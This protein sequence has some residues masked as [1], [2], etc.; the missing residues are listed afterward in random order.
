MPSPV[1]PILPDFRGS[2]SVRTGF[3]PLDLGSDPNQAP[4]WETNERE[5][6]EIARQVVQA[7]LKKRVRVFFV[8]DLYAFAHGFALSETA[9]PCFCAPRA[10]PTVRARGGAL[11]A[12]SR[13]LIALFA[14]S[15]ESTAA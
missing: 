3:V 10:C 7:P 12:C 11:Q 15:C 1:R 4:G 5:G 14:S 6:S 2:E 13:M 9:A 8:T